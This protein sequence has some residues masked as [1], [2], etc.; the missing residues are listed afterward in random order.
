MMNAHPRAHPTPLPRAPG[1]QERQIG[2][3]LSD[4]G[5]IA[6]G[7]LNPGGSSGGGGVDAS[8]NGAVSN[9]DPGRQDSRFEP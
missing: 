3:I 2:G 5:S 8:S 4:V 6:S 7:I 9:S 1:L